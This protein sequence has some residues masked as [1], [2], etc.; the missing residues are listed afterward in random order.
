MDIKKYLLPTEKILGLAIT[1]HSLR[2]SLIDK[3]GKIIS[4]AVVGLEKGI[5][6]DKEIINPEK[7]EKKI[8]ELVNYI[9]QK[10]KIPLKKEIPTIVVLPTNLIFNKHFFLQ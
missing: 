10:N 6:S 5:V 9:R 7:L 3:S 8:T 4:Q 1:Q 2:A